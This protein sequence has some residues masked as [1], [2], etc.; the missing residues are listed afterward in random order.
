[1]SKA[2][3]GY[4]NIFGTPVSNRLRTKRKILRKLYHLN[5]PDI[6]ILP[7]KESNPTFALDGDENGRSVV[8]KSPSRLKLHATVFILALG[9]LYIVIAYFVLLNLPEQ[10]STYRE[11]KLAERATLAGI[12]GILM[13]ILACW[14]A[15]KWLA[16]VRTEYLLG[17]DHESSVL[18]LGQRRRGRSPVWTAEAPLTRCALVT[19]QGVRYGK[20]GVRSIGDAEVKGIVVGNVVWFFAYAMLPDRTPEPP[21]LPPDLPRVQL[22]S[23]MTIL[24]A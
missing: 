22:S 17:I 16:D 7:A 8:I 5:I 18:R 4:N 11:N 14:G 1:M 24:P 20:L 10:M 13:L 23:R 12:F 19:V 6:V 2:L 21:W 15:F 3:N 9:T